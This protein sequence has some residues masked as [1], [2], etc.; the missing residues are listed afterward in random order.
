MGRDNKIPES[1][2]FVVSRPK[3]ALFAPQAEVLTKYIIQYTLSIVLSTRPGPAGSMKE[4]EV[5]PT[6]I[7]AATTTASVW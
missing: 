6:I 7:G 5:V 3:R 4:K 1:F 2:F